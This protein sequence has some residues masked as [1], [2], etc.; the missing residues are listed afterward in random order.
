MKTTTAGVLLVLLAS[1]PMAAGAG[2][3]TARAIAGGVAT[4]YAQ[5][6]VYPSRGAAAASL[7]R[8]N[9]SAG[10]Y[11]HLQDAA[12]AARLTAD[13]RSVLH[14]L[15]A[16]VRYAPDVLPPAG[17]SEQPNPE[18]VAAQRERERMHGYGIARVAVLPGNVGYLDLRAFAGDPKTIDAL[19]GAMRV[20]AG[21]QAFILD[22][23]RN[24]GGESSTVAALVG[25]V[26]GPGVH[27][28]DFVGRGDGDQ[29]PIRERSFTPADAGTRIVAPVFVLTS[30]NTFS[31][32]EECAYDLQALKRATLVGQTT[33]G[34][35]NPGEFVR[36]SDHFE[37]FVSDGRARNPVTGTN[38]EGTGVKPDIPLPASDALLAAY[39]RGLDIV[40]SDPALGPASRRYVQAV[41]DRARTLTEAQLLGD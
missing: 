38:W 26:V 7:L 1:A 14:D 18:E 20:L 32:A 31:G 6:Y 35:A 25:H 4:A 40:A 19:D 36:I 27:V 22:L 13:L 2:D 28:N 5:R 34:G 3:A 30:K 23:R 29:A 15:H 11:D 37:A 21:T 41:R 39:A 10:T 16:Y 33:G 9:A 8:T 24:G 17:T 12:L